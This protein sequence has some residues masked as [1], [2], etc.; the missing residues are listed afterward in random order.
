MELFDCIMFSRSV[1]FLNGS[2]LRLPGLLVSTRQWCLLDGA[3]NRNLCR[4]FFLGLSGRLFGAVTAVKFSPVNPVVFA[5][6][7]SEGLIFFFNLSLSTSAPI[8]CLQVPALASSSGRSRG[9]RSADGSSVGLRPPVTGISFNVKQRDMFAACDALG[10]VH[11]WR[12]DRSLSTASGL[13]Q[14]ELDKIGRVRQ[15]AEP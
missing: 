13:D 6:S 11:V 9:N 10:R 2:R 1:P 12:L 5:C 7:T 14:A 4:C 3:S 8:L 15:V